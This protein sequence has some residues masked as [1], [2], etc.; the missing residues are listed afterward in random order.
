MSTNTKKLPKPKKNL[1][2]I[3]REEVKDKTEA[4]VVIPKDA[5]NRPHI[6]TVLA[7]GPKAK[8][9][10]VGEKVAFNNYGGFTLF[11]DDAEYFMI[12]SEHILASV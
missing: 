2:I 6:G 8:E 1:V 11:L 5:M 12:K 9:V 3:D 4:G 10:K 7:K